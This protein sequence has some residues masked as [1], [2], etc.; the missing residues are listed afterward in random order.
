MPLSQPMKVMILSLVFNE[1]AYFNTA[2]D[3][4]IKSLYSRLFES[5]SRFCSCIVIDDSVF[6]NLEQVPP[7][8]PPPQVIDL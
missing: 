4:C 7:R 2:S 8:P 3:E 6:F 5:G 1:D